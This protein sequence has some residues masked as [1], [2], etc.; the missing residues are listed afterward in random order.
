[1]IAGA[2]R[3]GR[4]LAGGGAAGE[5][6]IF[7][8]WWGGGVYVTRLFNGGLQFAGVTPPANG[9]RKLATHRT[10]VRFDGWDTVFLAG[11]DDGLRVDADF[12]GELEDFKRGAVHGAKYSGCGVR[13]RRCGMR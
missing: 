6:G 11:F 5:A 8:I 9:C 4:W 7:F 13:F 1:M 10:H 12:F 3:R 2:G